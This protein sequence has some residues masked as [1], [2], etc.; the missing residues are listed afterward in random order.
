M[1]YRFDGMSNFYGGPGDGLLGRS[2]FNHMMA[3]QPQ[4]ELHQQKPKMDVSE[5]QDGLRR[6][7][8]NVNVRFAE[9]L[10]QNGFNRPPPPTQQ[11]D[12]FNRNQ[13]QNSSIGKP[14]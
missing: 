3:S 7:L 5:W 2:G 1:F 11:N 4:P 8:P 14:F 13:F 9:N 6:L 10:Q 12:L